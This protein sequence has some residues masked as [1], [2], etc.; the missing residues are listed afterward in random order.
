MD[1][2]LFTFLHPC[3]KIL[4]KFI[5]G[6]CDDW[7]LSPKHAKVVVVIDPRNI[8]VRAVTGHIWWCK[9][10]VLYLVVAELGV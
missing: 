9:V 3:K 4:E 2:T 1:S 8:K 6:G 10:V 5:L 7:V